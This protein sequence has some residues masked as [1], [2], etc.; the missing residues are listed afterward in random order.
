[1]V[2]EGEVVEHGVSFV[3]QGFCGFWAQG[4]G[5]EQ[6]AICVPEVELFF[7]QAA[8]WVGCGW[9]RDARGHCVCVMR[10]K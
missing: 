7:G 3:E 10:C 6:V 4:I 5:D 1:M 8:A 2:V 9:W